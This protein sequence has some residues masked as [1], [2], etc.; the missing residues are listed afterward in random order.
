[1]RCMNASKSRPSWWLLWAPAIG[2]MVAIFA[3]SSVPSNDMPAFGLADFLVKKGGHMLGYALLSLSYQHALSR[4]RSYSSW[5][6]W[7][8]AVLFAISD[9]IH[10]IFVP[11]RGPLI[12]DVGI[13]ALGAGLSL[14][15][16]ALLWHPSN[17]E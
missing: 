5:F 14:M 9:E 12:S 7:F 3:F 16:S 6:A 8:F 4:N 2:M 11:G 13:D 15:L 1:M 10:Q 17:G